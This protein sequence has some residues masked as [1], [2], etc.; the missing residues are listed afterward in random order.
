[1]YT[2]KDFPLQI[3]QYA[4]NP[5]EMFKFFLQDFMYSDP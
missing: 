4:V 2:L 1:M 5:L 3:K